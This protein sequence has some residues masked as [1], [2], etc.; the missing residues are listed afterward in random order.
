VATEGSY[1]QGL[2]PDVHSRWSPV[3]PA[4]LVTLT[5]FTAQKFPHLPFL[6]ESPANLSSEGLVL[7]ARCTRVFEV[8]H[9]HFVWQEWDFRDILGSETMLCVTG[10]STSDTFPS[11]WQAW[12][13]LHIA[14]VGRHGSKWEVLL[15]VM[16]CGRRSIWRTWTTFWKGRTSRVAGAGLRMPRANFSWQAQYNA[17]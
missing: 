8:L 1:S 16:S 15:E 7:L 11:A 17:L 9:V 12:L 13:F 6:A 4:K 2:R 3:C 10:A 5:D 14:K